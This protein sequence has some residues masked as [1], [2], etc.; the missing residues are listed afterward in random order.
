MSHL[1]ALNPAKR[2]MGRLFLWFWMTCIVTALCAIAI[3]RLLSDNAALTAPDENDIAILTSLG[4]RL[5][6]DRAS[7]FRPEPILKRI[8]RTSRGMVVLFNPQ[9]GDIIKPAGPPLR[10]PDVDDINR[11]SR[12][13]EPLSLQRGIVHITGPV[14]T[15]HRGVDYQIFLLR[16]E[17]KDPTP[18]R[19]ILYISIALLMTMALSYLFARTL[20]RPILNIQRAAGAL[21][22][23]DWH[24]RVDDAS[25]RKDELGI[26]SR[27]FNT[28]AAQLERMWTTQKRL[29]ADISHELRSPLTRLQMALGIAHQQ[30]VDPAVLARIEREANRM[31]SLIQQLLTLSRAEAG[32]TTHTVVTLRD[33]LGD[34][35]SDAE[36][37]ANNSGKRL[38]IA[39]VP[40][41]RVRVDEDLVRRAIDNVVRNALHYANVDVSVSVQVTHSDWHITVVDDGPGLSFQDCERIFAPFY[42][43]SEARDRASGG[44]GLGLSIA[45]AAVEMHDGKISASPNADG[46]LRVTLSFPRK[47][48]V[49]ELDI[50]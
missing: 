6:S 44:A 28:M 24:T 7:A 25:T 26:L 38:R 46:G 41:L 21:A 40:E 30:Q 23:G 39:A 15:V 43:V 47:D 10:P 34:V 45:K 36:F 16:L 27:D 2:L 22:K 13:A 18:T 4:E 8:S 19:L 20:V 9:T 1:T 50:H 35:L 48:D 29:L 33:L 5:R 42:R 11:L 37:E 17:S 3:T 32:E 14:D 12:Q 31:E 49:H